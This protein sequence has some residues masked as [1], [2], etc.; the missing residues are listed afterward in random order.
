M[1][2][3]PSSPMSISSVS[4]PSSPVSRTSLRPS[5]TQGKAM[6]C[7][8]SLHQSTTWPDSRRNSVSGATGAWSAA[9]SVSAL[10][11]AVTVCGRNSGSSSDEDEAVR[12]ADG[13]GGDDDVDDLSGIDRN[14]YGRA[15]TEEVF[16]EMPRRAVQFSRSGGGSLKP[17]TRS[18]MRITRE[19][20]D[21]FAPVEA[22]IKHEAEVTM[23]FR[24]ESEDE[25]EEDEEEGGG[26][27]SS[28]GGGVVRKR[29]ASS[30]S[31]SVV[32]DEDEVG[33]SE[34]KLK[35]RGTTDDW[36]EPYVIKRRAVSPGVVVSGSPPGTF[37]VG[38]RSMKQMQE[39]F[40]KIQKMSL[41]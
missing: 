28:S 3:R 23:A 30:A 40:D 27:N 18:F 26:G 19:L 29:A 41:T 16:T 10:G 12:P 9:S 5:V 7:S 38:K 8:T 4:S 11:V 33:W 6:R 37:A 32:E 17:Q 20:L 2:D 21:E 31:V 25:D 14:L 22:E 36:F 13:G 34:K 35:R 1:T 39:T 15:R 24:D